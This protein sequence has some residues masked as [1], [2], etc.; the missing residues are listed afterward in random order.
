M[1]IPVCFLFN[2]SVA[3]IVQN[4]VVDNMEIFTILPIIM[5]CLIVIILVLTI[6]GWQ[7]RKVMKMDPAKI[8]TKE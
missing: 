7:I 4:K 3:E 8:T 5:G 6:V 2:R 1:S